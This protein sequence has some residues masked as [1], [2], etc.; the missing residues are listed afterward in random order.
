MKKVLVLILVS[1]LF[2]GCELDDEDLD[3]ISTKIVTVTITPTE[4]PEDI[5]RAN[6]ELL[7][8]MEDTP[9]QIKAEEEYTKEDLEFLRKELEKQKNDENA[10][11]IRQIQAAIDKILEEAE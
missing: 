8:S 6:Q 10:F 4:S 3:E 9:E 11:K 2:M 1:I 5:A 7:D